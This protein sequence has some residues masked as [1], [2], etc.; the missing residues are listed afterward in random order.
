[1]GVKDKNTE[2]FFLRKSFFVFI[3]YAKYVQKVLVIS[4]LL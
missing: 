1:M 4:R 2:V 3:Y